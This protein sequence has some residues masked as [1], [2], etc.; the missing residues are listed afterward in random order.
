MPK[1][2][3]GRLRRLKKSDILPIVANFIPVLGV[4]FWGWSAVEAFT[5]YAMETLIV[6]ILTLLKLLVATVARK[7]D[8]WYNGS[9]TTTVSGLFFMFFFTIHFGI[10]AAVQ[11]SIFSEVANL[12][13]KGAGP[14]YFFLNW[15][16]FINEHTSYALAAFVV[17]YVANN[18]IPFI[19]SGDYKTQ[20]M[21]LLMFQPYGRIII[22]QFTVILGSMMLVF[23]F[24]IGFMVVFVLAKLYF[25]LFINFDRVLNKTVDDM[26]KDVNEEKV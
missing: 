11:T 19:V 3:P 5:V 14:L 4:A 17:S 6:G 22:Q 10:F 1:S 2:L 15:Y 20:P 23:N 12:E 13:P 25:E 24:G 16:K 26:K 9:Q 21:M 7:H 8:T 18:F